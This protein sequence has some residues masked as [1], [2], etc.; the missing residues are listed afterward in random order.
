MYVHRT[1][2]KPTWKALLSHRNCANQITPL[3]L[4]ESSCSREWNTIRS[5]HITNQIT[6]LEIS[7]PLRLHWNTY[8]QI[9]FESYQSAMNELV[10][11]LRCLLPLR[12]PLFAFHLCIFSTS[13]R[14]R[15]T[16]SLHYVHPYICSVELE[17][18]HRCETIS[19]H[20]WYTYIMC[21]RSSLVLVPFRRETRSNFAVH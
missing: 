6:T 8:N 2:T 4:S 13:G 20:V 7:T 11:L 1:K 12:F 9:Y 15:R 10:A 17:D 16:A 21:R 14:S 3:S 5:H 19:N 18:N